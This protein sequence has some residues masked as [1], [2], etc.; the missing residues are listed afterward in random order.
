[1]RK[2]GVQNRWMAL[3]LTVMLLMQ[4]LGAS[5]AAEGL[6]VRL[7]AA[8]KTIDEEAFA[9]DSA[10]ESVIVPDGAERIGARAF[11][12]NEHL[13]TIEIPDSVTKIADDAFAGSNLASIVCSPDGTAAQYAID[14][15]IHASYTAMPEL[16]MNKAVAAL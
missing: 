5:G 3:L 4:L 12:D 2:N 7:P 9:G 15:D 11:A 16:M 6:A 14:H 1:M 8:V 13:Q 10:I